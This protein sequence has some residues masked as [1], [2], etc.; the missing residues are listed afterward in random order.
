M[1]KKYYILS[2][3]KLYLFFDFILL[4]GYILCL[5]F[6]FTNINELA[7]RTIISA[8]TLNTFFLLLSIKSIIRSFQCSL[9]L[10]CDE[11]IIRNN[12]TKYSSLIEQYKFVLTYSDIKSFSTIVDRSDTRGREFKI[13]F[14]WKKIRPSDY[15]YHYKKRLYLVLNDFNGK[16]YRI[17]V[18][19]YCGKDEYS[20]IN[21]IIDRIKTARKTND[22]NDC[23]KKIKKQ[24]QKQINEV[25]EEMLYDGEK[26]Y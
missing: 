20:L 21:D 6:Y 26:V 22:I 14:P 7:R 16:T 12:K 11:I 24:L 3:F 9:L 8:L 15:S 4:A 13:G 5:S 18:Q 2:E 1:K 25:E 23:I 10:D 19:L 17:N